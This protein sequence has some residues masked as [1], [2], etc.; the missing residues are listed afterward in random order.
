[1][2]RIGR[3]LETQMLEQLKLPCFLVLT[4][5]GSHVLM[6]ME[7]VSMKGTSWE[8]IPMFQLLEEQ[9]LVNCQTQVD[10]HDA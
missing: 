3:S 6:E 5:A 9:D 7:M 8:L 2:A 4:E 10:Q 1:M